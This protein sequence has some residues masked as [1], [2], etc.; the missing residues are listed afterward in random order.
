MAKQ[1]RAMREY[2]VNEREKMLCLLSKEQREKIENGT[3]GMG[4]GGGGHMPMRGGRHM[5]MQ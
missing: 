1:M 4:W 5:M 3:W 2:W